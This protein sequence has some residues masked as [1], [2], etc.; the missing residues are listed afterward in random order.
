VSRL[1]GAFGALRVALGAA[2]PFLIHTALRSGHAPAAALGLVAFLAV[3]LAVSWHAAGAARPGLVAQHVAF[4]ALG[5]AAL[6]LHEA[7]LLQLLPTLVSVGFLAAF[8]ATLRRGA[9][10]AIVRI[11]RRLE[12][13]EIPPAIRVWLRDVTVAW[14]GFFAL[15]AVVSGGLALFG[16]LR[17]WT[18]W[19][20]VLAYV[21]IAA[22]LLGEYVVRKIR[23]RWYRDGLLDRFWRRAFPPF[24]AADH[25]AGRSSTVT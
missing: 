10:P 20:G 18:L 21:A 4:A 17:W 1:A 3:S 12:R 23:F 14:C 13:D 8:S 2:Y 22:L 5:G 19:T 24:P 7:R 11:A 16:P 15:N 9:E 6:L 25:E